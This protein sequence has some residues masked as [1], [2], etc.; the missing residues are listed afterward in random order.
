[1]KFFTICEFFITMSRGSLFLDKSLWSSLF[2]TFQKHSCFLLTSYFIADYNIDKIL[3][4]DV[5][6]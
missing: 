1:M 2:L 5:C 6:K 3:E 4:A